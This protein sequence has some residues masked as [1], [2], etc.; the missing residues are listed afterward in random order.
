[1]AVQYFGIL[2][3]IREIL[4]VFYKNR[5]IRP[6][7]KE[8]DISFILLF[9]FVSVVV[10][11]MI[12]PLI[13][14]GS[15]S[16]SNM[17][18]TNLE[19]T[20]LRLT[21][22][23]YG[24]PRLVIF[25]AIFTY[26]IVIKSLTLKNIRSNYKIY[27]TSVL[28]VAAW[29]MLQ[30]ICNLYGKE[31]PDFIFNTAIHDSVIAAGTV[32]N[33]GD[34][35]LFRIW[36]V[37]LEPSLFAQILVSV[38]PIFIFSLSSNTLIYSKIF[39]FFSLFVILIS[40]GLSTSTSAYV[41]VIVSYLISLFFIYIFRV[42]NFYNLFCFGILLIILSIFCY[43]SF[44][45][46]QEYINGLFFEKS[47]TGSAIERLY[48][49]T[50]AWEYFLQYPLLGLGWG[51]VTSHDLIVMIL[52]NA[53]II[54]LFS[55]FGMIVYIV[56]RSISLLKKV[57]EIHRDKD[58]NLVVYGGGALSSLLTFLIVSSFTEFTWYLPL[59]YFMLG[60]VI[61][62]NIASYKTISKSLF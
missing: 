28:F 43:F 40:L 49:I 20:P 42:D 54:G 22:K 4:K 44:S 9:L 37:T 60:I 10:L 7:S 35:E 34:F 1:M 41:G 13:I 16:I 12:M 8:N 55:F 47:N 2:L 56:W 50:T 14:D 30:V 23:N 62:V 51:V 15:I 19:E 27:I 53:G 3:I 6:L 46:F 52:A 39:D 33:Y 38:L 59:F 45:F 26:I 61:A 57:T 36:S 32:T 24:N 31:F 11:S 5:L 17:K 18:L 48:S 25:G 58:L 29:G 21:D